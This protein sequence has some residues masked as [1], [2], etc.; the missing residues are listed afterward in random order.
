MEKIIICLRCGSGAATALGNRQCWSLAWLPSTVLN[1]KGA[2]LL[3]NGHTTSVSKATEKTVSRHHYHQTFP[4][5][6]YQLRGQSPVATT[7]PLHLSPSLSTNIAKIS[8][9]RC[10]IP[11]RLSPS[12]LI[13]NNAHV[14]SSTQ[15]YRQKLHQEN[16]IKSSTLIYCP[17]NKGT[18]VGHRCIKASRTRC[19]FLLSAHESF[20]GHTGIYQLLDWP[21]KSRQLNFALQ[22]ALGIGNRRYFSCFGGGQLQYHQN[23]HLLTNLAVQSIFSRQASS[24]SMAELSSQQHQSVQDGVLKNGNSNIVQLSQVRF[25]S[26]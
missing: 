6:R 20:P 14:A 8:C 19:N 17:A 11:S 13:S 24:L 10:F 5:R 7:V 25:L 21:P 1:G 12:F 26:F 16:G 3:S 23:H 4:Q 2:R 15:V 9:S 22:E 18:P